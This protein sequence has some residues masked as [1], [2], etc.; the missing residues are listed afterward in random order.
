MI[1]T[2]KVKKINKFSWELKGLLESIINELK[3]IGAKNIVA[4]CTYRSPETDLSAFTEY[5]DGFLYSAKTN[6][7]LY[8][9]IQY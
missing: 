7:F 9:M 8:I 6:R 5:V 3:L 2:L 1:R 4:S